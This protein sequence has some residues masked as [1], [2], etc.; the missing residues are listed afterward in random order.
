MPRRRGRTAGADR[1]RVRRYLTSLS[2]PVPSLPARAG[3]RPALLLLYSPPEP[4]GS[5]SVPRR[6]ATT[7]GGVLNRARPRSWGEGLGGCAD[8]D[9][10]AHHPTRDWPRASLG[11][12]TPPTAKANGGVSRRMHGRTGGAARAGQGPV[13][14]SPY[15]SQERTR[16]DAQKPSL[17]VLWRCQR[18]HYRQPHV[19]KRNPQAYRVFELRASSHNIRIAS[20]AVGVPS[21]IE[22]AI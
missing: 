10:T 2:S 11:A 19:T 15:D 7:G 4:S 12:S 9:R 16:K 14:R 18:C 17:P 3:F 21:G 1:G 22:A 20:R 8:D 6:P 13:W 5:R